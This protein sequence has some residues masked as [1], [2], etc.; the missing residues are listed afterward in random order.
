M[1]VFKVPTQI[2]AENIVFNFSAFAVDDDDDDMMCASSVV[3]IM[4]PR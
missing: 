4:K 3:R 2:Q 1:Y